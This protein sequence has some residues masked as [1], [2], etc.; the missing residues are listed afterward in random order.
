MGSRDSLSGL[1]LFKHPREPYRAEAAPC[2]PCEQARQPVLPACPGWEGQ[3][4]EVGVSHCSSE[5]P[6]GGR[7][8]GSQFPPWCGKW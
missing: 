1:C 8:L 6:A 5:K 7:L 3:P 2:S 4:A